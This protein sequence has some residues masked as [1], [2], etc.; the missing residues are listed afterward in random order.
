M[1]YRESISIITKYLDTR[2][3]RYMYLFLRFPG[4]ESLINLEG[5]S[6][7]VATEIYYYFERNNMT[8]SLL[9]RVNQ[10]FILD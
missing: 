2:D 7:S 1:E 3:K 6:K 10:D 4:T 9:A 5:S 8:G